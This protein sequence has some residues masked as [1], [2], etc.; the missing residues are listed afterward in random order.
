[1]LT[2]RVTEN[3]G[4]IFTRESSEQF[5]Y[6]FNCGGETRYSQED[7]VYRARSLTL[8]TVLG[9]EA[10]KRGVRAFVEMST[11]MVY[12]PD[13]SPSKEA[14]G[15]LKPWLRLAKWKLTAEEELAKMD[16]LNLV[17]LRLAHV[18]GPYTAKFLGTA[19][20][21][22]RVYQSEGREMKWLWN[23]DLRTNTVHAED[24]ARAAWSAAEWYA[25][26]SPEKRERVPIFNIV[27]RGNTCKSWLQSVLYIRTVGLSGDR[28]QRKGRWLRSSTTFSTF[29]LAS[30]ELSCLSLQN[31][32]LIPWSTTLMTRRWILGQIY[33]RS[34]A[35][36]HQRH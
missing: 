22:A 14:T 13:S 23:E 4:R 28:L 3:L 5:D 20:C 26:S 16:G 19:L 30:K 9:R 36:T 25:K 12:K 8:S 21:L 1:L 31:C 18:Y 29:Q 6:V 24:V 33:R 35:Q 10:A 7:E 11:G 34:L 27:D 17:V 15:K 32:T 2:P